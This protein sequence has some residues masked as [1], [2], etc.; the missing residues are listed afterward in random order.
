MQILLY[1]LV[2]GLVLVVSMTVSPEAIPDVV[3]CPFRWLTGKLCPLCGMTHAFSAIGHGE[4]MRALTY[5]PLGPLFWGLFLLTAV[6]PT[7][8]LRRWLVCCSYVRRCGIGLLILVA[9]LG[10]YRLFC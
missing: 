5:N 1:S 6:Y 2:C 7:P 4:Y 8:F 10:L 9:T 3:V